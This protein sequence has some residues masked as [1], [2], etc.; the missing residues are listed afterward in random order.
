M[1]A[2]IKRPKALRAFFGSRYGGLVQIFALLFARLVQTF[3][4]FALDRTLLR[5]I[6]V[7]H[8]PLLPKEPRTY[9]VFFLRVAVFVVPAALRVERVFFTPASP[10]S[11]ASA[12]ADFFRGR[13]G[14]A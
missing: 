14:L 7:V 2:S 10:V 6:F 12:E 11:D 8:A 3:G 13:F 1:P 4:F 5:C 9:V